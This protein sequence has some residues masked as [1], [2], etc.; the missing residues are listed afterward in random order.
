M[1]QTTTRSRLM[2]ILMMVFTMIVGFIPTQ[3]SA[4]PTPV[5]LLVDSSLGNDSA[6]RAEG[7]TYK[8]FSAALTK[9]LSG[10]TIKLHSDITLLNGASI[11][12]NK[13]IIVNLNGYNLIKTD[14]YNLIKL[15]GT[16][17]LEIK[18]TS[19]EGNGVLSS[20]FTG[21]SFLI[22]NLGSGTVKISSGNIHSP[23]GGAILCEDGVLDIAG[24]TMTSNKQ[25]TISIGGPCN[26]FISGGSIVSESSKAIDVFG[27]GSFT[28]TGGSI[29]S[30]KTAIA[31]GSITAFKRRNIVISG[32]TIAS[33]DEF[34]IWDGFGHTAI[35]GGNL[36]SGINL[37]SIDS[38]LSISGNP[39]T[40]I[41]LN[42]YFP[43]KITITNQL[44]GDAKS[45]KLDG[46]NLVD[47]AD[48]TVVATATSE[49]YLDISKFELINLPNKVLVKSGSNLILTSISNTDKIEEA[50]T[51]IEAAL[52]KLSINNATT[53]DEI[54]QATK[55]AALYGVS[56]A[57]D[58]VKGFSKVEATSTAEGLIMGTLNLTL[59]DVSESIIVNQTIE[60][61]PLS[62]QEKIALAKT[63]IEATLAKLSISNATTAEEI[64]Q[65]AKDATLY[66]VSVAWDDIKG[67]SKV[68]ATSTAKGLITGTLALKHNKES[69]NIVLDL[70]INQLAT[71]ETQ[72]K[73]ALKDTLT[74]IKVEGVDG[75]KFDLN[76]QLVVTPIISTIDQRIKDKYTVGIYALEK[77]ATLVELYD[78]KLMLNG[79]AIQPNG[80]V[81]VTLPLSKEQQ[82]FINFQI[83]YVD[84][85]G[86]I[87]K[88]N[89][90]ISNNQ[91]T[92]LTNHFSFYGIIGAPISDMIVDTSDSNNNHAW[93][94]MLSGCVF[95][96][97]S[98]KKK[99]EA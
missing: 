8:T 96:I 65:A 52:A 43:N 61:L 48:K 77:D 5:T 86:S 85:D 18:D 46:I 94:L 24:G 50:K 91:I 81:K 10:D 56:V 84:E 70:T 26:T 23:Y 35:S 34:S 40:K 17:S 25:P 31:G 71:T 68:E 42:K 1:K 38:K 3:I 55:D 37:T 11:I 15:S 51:N 72:T 87:V 21:F 75:T 63:N 20:T 89:S 62:D 53:A 27:I 66:G 6:S 95:I 98:N 64:L 14:Q 16:A 83:V 41:L 92:F 45:I 9:S 80:M 60:Q 33:T 90:S 28:M 12:H 88:V 2:M 13:N 78:I 36:L 22:Y 76:T 19:A 47:A 73:I 32:G 58:I 7:A 54:L 82:A 59:N 39:S 97:I 93:W 4:D 44:T 29:T 79:D 30:K 99:L 69:G 57:W 49:E 67:F 74:G